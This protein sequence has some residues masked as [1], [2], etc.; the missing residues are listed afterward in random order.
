MKKTGKI[1]GERLVTTQQ[2]RFLTEYAECL[3][4]R[5]AA[6]K[7]GYTAK[8][9]LLQARELLGRE[10]YLRTLDEIIAQKA[11][12]LEVCPA[13]VVKKY[14]QLIF[15]ATG[16]GSVPQDPP[17]LL[18]ALDGLCKHLSRGDFEGASA[19][20]SMLTR[21]IGLNQEKI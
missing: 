8:S 20:E 15:W 12:A 14:L 5:S 6:L 21:I 2:R 4:A 9:A 11:A 10:K 13:F 17:I 18:R 3:D 19:E 16:E 1:Q 7:A